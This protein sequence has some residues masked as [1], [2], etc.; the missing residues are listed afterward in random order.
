MTD[1]TRPLPKTFAELE[2]YWTQRLRATGRAISPQRY[3]AAEDDPNCFANWFPTVKELGIPSPESDWI[4]VPAAVQDVIMEENEEDIL[5]ALK[6]MADHVR[7]FAMNHGYPV[8]I[9]NSLSAC[10]DGWRESCFIQGPDTNIEI[11]AA[12]IFLEWEIQSG[13][14]ARFL[15]VR[16]FLETA[17]VFQA[18]NG[19]PINQEF[20]LVAKEGKVFGYL[21][22]YAENQISQPDCED[23][24]EKLAGISVPSPADLEAMTGYAEKI[25]K[26][27]PGEWAIDFLID[28]KGKVWMIDMET[29]DYK[30][31]DR[32]D[33]VPTKAV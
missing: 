6:P 30:T 25:S 4:A 17:P 15:V 33:F 22:L 5:A 26:A 28:A 23:W 31:S 12:T 21:P 19:T 11:L 2:E 13:R 7:R 27:L 3:R 24:R 9:K 16:E 32:K 10:K 14:M 29:V 20:R 8:F 18:F 1:N